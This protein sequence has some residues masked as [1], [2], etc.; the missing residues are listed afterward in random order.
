MFKTKVVKKIET[1]ILCAVTFSF[2][3]ESRAVHEI[4]WKNVALGRPQVT[5]WRVLTACWIPKATDTHN[6]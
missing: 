6:M 1:H 3:P 4:M 5:M 2:S